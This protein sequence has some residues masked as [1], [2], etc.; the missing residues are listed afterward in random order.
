M[1]MLRSV[2]CSENEEA[3][4][5]DILKAMDQYYKGIFFT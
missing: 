2:I 5:P 4:Y 3:K 1:T